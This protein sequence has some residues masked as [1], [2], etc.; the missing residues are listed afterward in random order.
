MALTFAD[1]HNMIAY[2]TKSDV[3]EG[4]DQII[5]FLNASSIKASKGFSG[6]E[7]HLFE[8]MIV[9]QQADDVVD[10]GV[11]G[12]DVDAILAST[13]EPSIPSPTPTTQPP[14]RTTFYLTSYTYFTSITNC[15]TIITSTTTTNFITYT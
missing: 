15:S 10:E 14:P 4:F 13:N 6:L 1:T 2:L 3:S 8:G 9:A 7:T 11:A 12:V 5:D